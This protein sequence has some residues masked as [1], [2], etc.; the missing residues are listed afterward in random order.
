MIFNWKKQRTQ[1]L[2]A[3]SLYEPLS[4]AEQ[5]EL[6][7][8]LE[9]DAALRSEYESIRRLV[10]GIPET[11]AGPVPDLLPLLHKR[12]GAAPRGNATF[13]LA[14][15]AA[16]ILLVAVSLGVWYANR[17]GAASERAAPVK[18][19]TADTLVSQALAEAETLL[20]KNDL[21]TA[22]EVLR[23]AVSR[24]PGDAQA[25]KAQWLVADCAFKLK[26]YPDAYAACNRLFTSYSSWLENDAAIRA[27]AI[28]L[29]DLLEEARQVD[30]ASLQ[31]FDAAKR[32]RTNT[33][34]ALEKVAAN[35]AKYQGTE[36]Y[37]LGDLVAKEM[38]A[39]VALDAGIDI[40]TPAGALAAYQQA[41]DRCTSPVVV[42]L[43]D[44]KIGDTYIDNL[45]DRAAA[46]EHYRRA[47]ENPMLASLAT[48]ALD[49]LK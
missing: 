23:K 41:H 14:Y 21:P 31:A 25:G 37:A 29:R 13:H 9:V 7:R 36:Q 24:Q 30:F 35:Y 20:A 17:G 49:R 28:N 19:A 12:L 44:M 3:A 10:R 39:A 11:M 18:M 27:Q 15:G 26:R 2:M 5:R 43:L 40:A 48:K 34:A 1:G 4:D 22:F 38:A 47:A 42:A 46:R 45:H 16:A 8:A 6:D 32:D 33:F